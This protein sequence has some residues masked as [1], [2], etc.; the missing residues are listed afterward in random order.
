[1]DSEDEIVTTQVIQKT[2]EDVNVNERK[3][4]TNKGYDMDE[5]HLPG[6]PIQHSESRSS[7]RSLKKS[8]SKRESIGM[9]STDR[10]FESLSREASVKES[11]FSS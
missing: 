5:N 1:M 11:S 3:A 9:Q 10:T 7:I 2:A 4:S 8:L 6:Q